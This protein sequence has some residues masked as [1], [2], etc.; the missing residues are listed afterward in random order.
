MP[1]TPITDREIFMEKLPD[2]TMR[3]MDFNLVNTSLGAMVEPRNVLR[4]D[5]GDTAD[6]N[7]DDDSFNRVTTGRRAEILGG[8]ELGSLHNGFNVPERW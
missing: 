7:R 8:N 4:T 3:R 2:G 6:D 5:G 1:R